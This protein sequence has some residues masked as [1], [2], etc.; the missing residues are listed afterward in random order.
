MSLMAM[1]ELLR[2][3]D[4]VLL[5]WLQS[6]L[7]EAEIPAV[8]FDAHTSSLYGGALDAVT[9]RVMVDEADI[10]R[11]RLILA[12]AERLA[13]ELPPAGNLERF[14]AEGADADRIESVLGE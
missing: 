12:E 2:T 5:G 1:I 8:V 13:A 14:V 3:Q 10:G 4:P 11:A 6:R 7:D 9:R